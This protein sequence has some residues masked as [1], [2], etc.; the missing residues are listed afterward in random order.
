MFKQIGDEGRLFAHVSEG[1]PFLCSCGCQFVG[2]DL[3]LVR[4]VLG[5]NWECVVEHDA[6][7]GVF[8]CSVFI[9]MQVVCVKPVI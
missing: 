7:D 3:L 5:G 2:G 8:F 9:I 6:V 4:W 1:G